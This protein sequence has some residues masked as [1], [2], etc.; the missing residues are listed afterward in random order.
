MP[1]QSVSS[2]RT[3]PKWILLAAGVVGVVL[4]VIAIGG[5]AYA[6][7]IEENDGFCASCHTEPEVT[8]FNQST[9]Q[10]AVTLA[11]MHAQ[12]PGHETRCIDCHS[13]GGTFGRVDGLMQG[14]VDLFAYW[15]GHYKTPAVTTN[16]LGDDSCLKCHRDISQRRDF[17]NHFH[18]LLPRWQQLDANAAKCVTCHVAHNTNN[19][20]EGFLNVKTVRAVCND[21]HRKVGE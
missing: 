10:P 18:N 12:V 16:P 4:L 1:K 15:S 2:S 19:D 13:G 14:Q 9:T 8:F 11:S 5:T 6:L 17:N 3:I 20:A 7:H 21:C